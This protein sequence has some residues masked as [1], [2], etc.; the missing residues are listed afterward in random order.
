MAKI[1]GLIFLIVFAAC[2]ATVNYF[3]HFYAR[4]ALQSDAEQ[5]LYQ[6]HDALL[7]AHEVL[8][9]LP[10]PEVF[11]CNPE[12]VKQLAY[13]TFEHPAVRLLGIL[14]GDQQD[15][16]SEP[17]L[18]DLSN[19]H[20]RILSRSD[21]K[22]GENYFLSTAGQGAGHL[23]LLMIRAHGDARYFASINPFMVDYLAEFACLDCL[24]YDFVIDGLPKLEFK[25]RAMKQNS[26]I[27]Y[28]TSRMEGALNVD[29][30]V[31]GTEAFF[32]YYRELSWASTIVFSGLVASLIAF[33]SYKLLTL[34]QSL[35]R[36]IKDAIK[37]NEFIPYYQ[38]I[39]DSRNGAVIGA[40][41]LARW[42]RSDGSVVPPYQFIPFA[43]DTGLILD[44][45]N[46]LVVRTAE[47]ILKLQWQNGEKFMSINIV[48]DHLKTSELF[49]LIT[50][51]IEE[52][53]L[54]PASISLEI[55]ERMQIDDL[56]AARKSLEQFFDKGIELKL[57]DA[58]TG[59]G[60][61]SYIQE[62]GI[63]TLKIDKM[64][65]DTIEKDDVKSSVLEA[66][67]SF[68][69]SSDLG[70]IAEGVEDQYQVDYLKQ[71]GVFSIQ[72]YVYGK[73]MPIGEFQDW[74]QARNATHSTS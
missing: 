7:E 46:R 1:I 30:Y 10:D 65:I 59:Y 19:Y 47:D 55:T 3:N 54:S 17:I 33:L 68:A 41:V 28:K 32:D 36:V 12:T 6:F 29:L 25:S 43:E 42:Q 49:D 31:R 50:A 53:N 72:G 4:Q 35:E 18:V 22:V 48:P 39:V 27:E 34:R 13:L 66:I 74:L 61:F 37:F 9:T 60:G 45:T 57:D 69:K 15:C 58:G 2:M 64:F 23:D 71:R 26:V 11:A 38:P 63:S 73:P 56:Q 20:E 40:E 51:Q 24:E 16:A 70:M 52:R 21:H 5:L 14:H 62:L 8:D 67:I 44:I